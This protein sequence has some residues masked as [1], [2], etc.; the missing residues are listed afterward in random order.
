MT[1]IIK[2]KVIHGK[3]L[4]RTIGFKTA[5]I[6]CNS[7]DIDDGVYKINIIF[8]GIKFAGVG[9]YLKDKGIF[10]AHLFDFDKDIYDKEIEIYLLK[11]IRNNKKFDSI[12]E[13]K[14]QIS[15]DIIF[16]K[17]SIIKVMTF[18]TFDIFHLGHRYF[19]KNASFYGDCLITIVA[20][21]INVLKF[22]G[23][24]PKN[25]ETKRGENLKKTKIADIVELGDSDNPL[26][27]VFIHNPQIICLGYDQEGFYREL[28]EN[29]KINDIEIN[30][31]QSYK[32]E[33]YKSSL[34]KM[35]N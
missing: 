18:G 35:I 15:K 19:L 10:E 4:G 23:I 13:L 29:K 34:L 21:D 22:K 33:I 26:F 24:K 30:R 6:V 20:R 8:Y 11:K 17:K 2:G 7:S 3:E 9:T 32:P 31:I 1:F 5:N 14:S 16:A 27:W 28:K 12:D 25:N